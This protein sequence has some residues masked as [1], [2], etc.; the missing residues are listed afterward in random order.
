VK[1][2]DPHYPSGLRQEFGTGSFRMEALPAIAEAVKQDEY[3][4]V[5][6]ATFEQPEKLAEGLKGFLA[7]F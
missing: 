7:G 1:I 5:M 3:R 2:F 6:K 4:P